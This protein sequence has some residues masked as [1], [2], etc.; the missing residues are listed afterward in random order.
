[1]CYKRH[2]IASFK[3]PR[4]SGFFKTQI[5]DIDLDL[6]YF[7]H[8]KSPQIINPRILHLAVKRTTIVKLYEIELIP[9]KDTRRPVT[10]DH[11]V[12]ILV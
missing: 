9:L 1:M 10:A 4:I 5:S 2:S 12:Y 8:S 11:G 7:I 6:S 3:Q